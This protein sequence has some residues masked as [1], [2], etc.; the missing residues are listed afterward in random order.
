MRVSSSAILST[1]IAALTAVLAVAVSV[2]TRP[3]E[4]RPPD[5]PTPAATGAAP[6]DSTPA[7]EG[8]AGFVGVVISSSTVDV[9]SLQ[10][11]TILTVSARI[12]DV[13]SQGQV[14]VTLE[15]AEL[16]HELAMAQAQIERDNADIERAVLERKQADERKRRA[17]NASQHLNI[18]ELSSA[19][20]AAKFALANEKALRARKTQNVAKEEQLRERLAQRSLRA[21][22]DS[23]VSD[24]FLDPG[25]SV[26]AGTVVMRL[27]GQAGWRVRFAVPEGG[28]TGIAVDGG[29]VARLPGGTGEWRGSITEVAPALDPASMTRVAE[30]NVWAQDGGPPFGAMVR[31]FIEGPAR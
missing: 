8:D 9:A 4:R 6:S 1:A 3:L 26:A 10:D 19:L 25:A 12:G 5:A 21:P 11:G 16:R 20:Y 28:E 22:V 23:V 2:A 29:I 30:A 15:S 7:L 31:V 14:L 24:R 17:V 13:V 27:V 18:D